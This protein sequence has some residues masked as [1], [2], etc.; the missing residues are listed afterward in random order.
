MRLK[1]VTIKYVMRFTDLT[2]QN[3]PDTVHRNQ[4]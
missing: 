4:P 2:V 3:V 1:S